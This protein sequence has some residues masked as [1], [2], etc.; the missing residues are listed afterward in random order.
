LDKAKALDDGLKILDGELVQKYYSKQVEEIIKLDPTDTLG[1]KKGMEIAKASDEL[2]TTL[3]ALHG[4]QK[5]KELLAEVDGFIT[6]WSLTGSEKQ[7]VL[8][9]KF[10]VYDAKSLDEAEKLADEV[11]AI[12]AKTSFGEQA[13]SIKQQIA[14]MKAKGGAAEEEPADEAKDEAPAKEKETVQ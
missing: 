4:E 2:M 10:G 9:L 3:E 7:R 1:R 6:K 12:D 11:I 13:G 14:G 8:M 5:F